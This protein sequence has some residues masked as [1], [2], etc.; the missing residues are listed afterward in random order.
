MSMLC[1][2]QPWPRLFLKFIEITPSQF[3]N[4]AT[5][6]GPAAFVKLSPAVDAPSHA[7]NSAKYTPFSDY[8]TPAIFYFFY[9]FFFCHF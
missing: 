8:L 6:T 9:Y 7:A 2:M 4:A 5:E 3:R 1:F